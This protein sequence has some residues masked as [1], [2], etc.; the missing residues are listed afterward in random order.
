MLT[1]HKYYLL[2]HSLA[3]KKKQ[4]AQDMLSVCNI[5]TDIDFTDILSVQQKWKCNKN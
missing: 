5:G 4:V 1:L 3:K 2:V